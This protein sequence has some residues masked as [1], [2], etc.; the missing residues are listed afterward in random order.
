MKTALHSDSTEAVREKM[1]PRV[2]LGLSV[3]GLGE[4]L[5]YL[6]GGDGEGYPRGDF[7]GVNAYYIAVLSSGEEMEAQFHYLPAHITYSLFSV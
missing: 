7:E 2:T 6:V 1:A 3:V 5:P 4:E